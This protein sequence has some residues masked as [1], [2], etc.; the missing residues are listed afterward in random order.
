MKFTFSL[1]LVAFCSLT[2]FGQKPADTAQIKA[3]QILIK[4][5]V[6]ADE[7]DNQAK[8]V[9]FAA[10]RVFVRARLAQWLW[11]EGTDETGR[12]EQIA[13][14]AVEDLYEKENE[15]P[16]SGFLK[17]DLFSLLDT[18]AKETAKKL[19]AKYAV[20]S[21]EDLSNAAPLLDKAGG[22]KIVAAKIKKYLADGKDL[23][24]INFLLGVLQE[25]K[26]PEFLSILAEIINLEESGGSTFTTNS[27]TWT[28]DFFR[29]PNI[30]NN[31]RVRFYRIA[32]NKARS[33]LQNPEGNNI[34]A[35]DYLLYA[36]LPNVAANAPELAAEASGIKA[37]L[38]TRTSQQSREQQER[39][40]RIE[41][42]TDKLSAL[43]SEAEKTDEKG[44]EKFNLL[45]R[46]QLLAK[47]EGKF[48]LAV[49]L[50]E[51]AIEDKSDDAYPP[52][53]IRQRYHDQEL[54][55][56]AQSALERD[57]VDA[58]RYAVKKIIKELSKADVLRRIA[59]YYAG[60]KDSGS[61][62][63][64]Y[65][66]ALKLTTKAENDKLKFFT[67]FRLISA[68]QQIEP[69]RISEITSITAKAV[70]ALPT[71]NVED[72]PGTENFNNYVSTMMA[73]NFNLYSVTGSLA[74]ANKNEATD[75]ANRIN[76]K[77][78]RIVADFALAIDAIDSDLK[79]I[80]RK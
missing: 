45:I 64:A 46:A 43:I 44:G 13:V 35:A 34:L 52:P 22:D 50:M 20:R 9:L 74:K 37:A 62:L 80:K 60:K 29:D 24:A 41:E 32:L 6:L 30:P 25:K 27:L 21:D 3:Q 69:S 18:R 19:R 53:A 39:N 70:N 51:K 12:A 23:G 72:K 28:A 1:A 33:A 10:A 42:S 75:F 4:K 67:L 54:G 15:I 56:I 55:Y 2:F 8:N 40:Q 47:K 38:S 48:R 61:A 16:D 59:V 36:I 49:D 5:Q 17:A 31:L 78:V 65:D 58:A 71:L 68:A 79:Q 14:K 66:E 11:K 76:R 77:E 26:S 7:L 57:D 63:D 73:I